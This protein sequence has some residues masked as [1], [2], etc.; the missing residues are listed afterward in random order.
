M[1]KEEIPDFSERV[2]YICGPTKM[3]E[4]LAQILKDKLNIQKN[5]IKTENFIGY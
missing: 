1:I 2:F 5:M 4:G 3:V